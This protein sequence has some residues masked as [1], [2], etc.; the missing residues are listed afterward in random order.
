MVKIILILVATAV[1]AFAA[2]VWTQATLAGHH[3][4]ESIPASDLASISPYEMQ[5]KV[6]PNDLPVQYMKGDFN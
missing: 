4:T 6:K 1:P 3:A 5:L 2:G